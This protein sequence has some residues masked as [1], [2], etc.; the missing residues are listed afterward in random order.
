MERYE[1]VKVAETAASVPRG[2]FSNSRNAGSSTDEL[3]LSLHMPACVAAL[4]SPKPAATFFRVGGYR[5]PIKAHSERGTRRPLDLFGIAHKLRL[6]DGI[7]LAL[8]RSGAFRLCY[9]GLRQL[10]E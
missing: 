1:V 2:I 4:S 3:Y 10:Q 5:K 6:R 8:C 9:L 7:S